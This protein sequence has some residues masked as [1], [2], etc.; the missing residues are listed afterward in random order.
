MLKPLLLVWAAR[1]LEKEEEDEVDEKEEE[2]DEVRRI[3]DTGRRRFERLG[4][5]WERDALFCNRW[6][7]CANS[8]LGVTVFSS[9]KCCL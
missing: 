1:L 6:W 8:S 5:S 4:S 7:W 3:V 9:R 2:D